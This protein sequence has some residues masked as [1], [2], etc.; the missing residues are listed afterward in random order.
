MFFFNFKTYHPYWETLYVL[1]FDRSY[2]CYIRV[3]KIKY[4]KYNSMYH[5]ETILILVNTNRHATYVR[6][7]SEIN[8]FSHTFDKVCL[9]FGCVRLHMGQWWDGKSSMNW[10]H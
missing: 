10:E 3:I 4:D 9:V 2:E 1:F 8:F 5:E 6:Y 7:A